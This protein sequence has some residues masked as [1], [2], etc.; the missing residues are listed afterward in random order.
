MEKKL[1]AKEIRKAVEKV[2]EAM[3][4]VKHGQIIINMKDGIPTYVDIQ[5]RKRIG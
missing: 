3:D 5:E 1:E 4:S 2:I